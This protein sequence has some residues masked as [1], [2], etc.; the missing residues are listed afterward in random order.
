MCLF[1]CSFFFP[2]CS[3]VIFTASKQNGIIREERR[4]AGRRQNF[5]REHKIVRRNTFAVRALRDF[6]KGCTGENL[7]RWLDQP[8]GKECSA[9]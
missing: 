2:P 6:E 4:G 7:A 8:G 9:F 5:P 1:R 3:F